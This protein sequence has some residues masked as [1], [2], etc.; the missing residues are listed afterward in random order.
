MT[1][2][3]RLSQTPDQKEAAALKYA[4]TSAKS[5]ANNDYGKTEYELAQAEQRLDAAY[6]EVPFSLVR[7][8]EAKNE[9]KAWK[10]G[11]EQAAEIIKEC[12][13]DQQ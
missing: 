9:V 11:L 4:L 10:R 8:M 7:I 12:F 1:L 2:L 3:E 5:Q 13:P 6:L